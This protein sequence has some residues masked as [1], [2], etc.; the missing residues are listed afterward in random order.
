MPKINK[1]T[2]YDL[3]FPTSDHLDGSDAMN[4]D[5]DYS[6]AYVII[7]T[8]DGSLKGHS[9]AFTLGRGNDL[10]CKAIKALKHLVI[11]LDINW[12][13]EN[14]SVFSRIMTSDTQLRWVGPEKGIIH[15][16]SGAIINAVWD[17]I[18][19]SKKKPVWQ[20]LSDM[21]PKQI[22]GCIDFR[23]ITDFLNEDEAISILNT[24]HKNKSTRVSILEREGYPCYVT[25]A[26]WLGYS[27]EKLKR[28]CLEAKAK[29]F[30]YVKLKVGKNLK[31]DM[32]RLD[33]ART[34][35]G[36]D[37]KI[38]IDANQVWEVDQAIKWMKSLAEFN[39]YFIEEPTSPDDIIGHKKIKE[40]IYPIKVATG[41]AVQ[42]RIIFKQLISENAID[43]VQVD[44]CRM[45][46]LN[47]VLAV[48]LMA[49]KNNLPV[50]PHAGGV[51]L[52]EY[53]QHLAMIDYLCIS[54]RKSEQVIEYVDHLHEHFLNPCTINNAAY[55]LPKESG[56]SIEMK[57]DTLKDNLFKG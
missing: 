38:M 35:L 22:A 17:I 44:A 55:M 30:E 15:M 42:N 34:T 45:G 53:S 46:G 52:C 37:I 23:H 7:E 29:G 2:T 4:P 50:W 19:K 27:D 32:R 18:A 49:S 14:Q 48:Q 51:G 9:F 43:I 16:A 20:L 39:P 26:G 3:R 11:G 25:S 24:H 28:L 10:C 8:D 13:E 5:P 33:I 31:D 57:S 12:I 40:A 6:A 41:E 47:E 21:N 54:G 36:S 1:L 56:F